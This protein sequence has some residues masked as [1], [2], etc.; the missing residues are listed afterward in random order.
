M[1]DKHK[2][3]NYNEIHY[4]GIAH[5]ATENEKLGKYIVPKNTLILCSIWSTHMDESYWK[6]PQNFRP[7]RFLDVQGNII[8]HENFIPF[9]ETKFIL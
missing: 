9:G 8:Q 7:E 6:D 5:R 4:V 1:N 2:M 3:E